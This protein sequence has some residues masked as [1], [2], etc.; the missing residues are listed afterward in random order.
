MDGAR[1]CDATTAERGHNAIHAT[2]VHY[3][4]LRSGTITLHATR[5]PRVF[6]QAWC[7]DGKSEQSDACD[8]EWRAAAVV[9]ASC[10][11]T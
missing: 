10:L 3:H 8:G 4:M 7:S 11:L 6:P 2:D 9:A 1:L 5:N